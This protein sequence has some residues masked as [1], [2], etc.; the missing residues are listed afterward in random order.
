M[1]FNAA[2][3]AQ[4]D[5][6]I[7][8]AK[9]NSG[10]QK[11]VV[12]LALLKK[13]AGDAPTAEQ[14]EAIDAAQ[15]QLVVATKDAQEKQK[16]AAVAAV[17]ASAIAAKAILPRSP[18]YRAVTI[19]VRKEVNE[20]DNKERFLLLLPG[21]PLVIEATLM[22]KE[23]SFRARREAL[24]TTMLDSADQNKD[25]RTT[26]AEAL[27]SPRFTMGRLRFTTPQQAASFQR[28]FDANRDGFADRV[29]A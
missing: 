9:A 14:K 15:K 4:L 7:E 24:I 21:G 13:Q 8:Y 16:Q 6:T 17:K 29:E 18:Q 1:E 27:A 26:W 10:P 11:L 5:A 25:D 3:K 28:S 23:K 20:K 2:S 22:D 19:T 12:E